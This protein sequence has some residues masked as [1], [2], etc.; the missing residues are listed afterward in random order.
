[1]SLG[2]VLV[3]AAVLVG[4]V[5]RDR[6]SR[7][8]GVVLLAGLLAGVLGAVGYLGY[9][10]AHYLGPPLRMAIG[11]GL[12]AGWYAVMWAA[13]RPAIG[14]AGRGGYLAAFRQTEPDYVTTWHR[15]VNPGLQEWLEDTTWPFYEEVFLNYT[16]VKSAP[17]ALLWR[18]LGR[19]WRT[20]D[21]S[22][23]VSYD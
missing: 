7:A 4:W 13:A 14:P 10:S 12:V 21:E 20:P 23:R 8:V 18:R 16:P 19:P 3:L 2:P 1:L 5:S 11:V 9:M 22:E 15:A 6:E 17:Y